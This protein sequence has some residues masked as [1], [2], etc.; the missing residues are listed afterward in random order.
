MTNEAAKHPDAVVVSCDAL[1]SV[2]CAEI[3]VNAIAEMLSTPPLLD[4]ESRLV[5]RAA[6][7]S[8]EIAADKAMRL[9]VLLGAPEGGYGKKEAAK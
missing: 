9:A 1:A 7:E 5:A 6:Q 2:M 8:L 3:A 4:E